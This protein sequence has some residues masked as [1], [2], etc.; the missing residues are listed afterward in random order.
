[1]MDRIPMI[2]DIPMDS[3][4]ELLD[5]IK[6][7]GQLKIFV[8]YLL[9]KV[10]V[11]LKSCA[12]GKTDLLNTGDQCAV[13]TIEESASPLVPQRPTIKNNDLP[14]SSLTIVRV[15]LLSCLS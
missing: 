11:D 9:F 6:S 3:P 7:P 8:T 1:M 13:Q 15:I 10:L 2:V 14:F 5:I 12:K 4:M